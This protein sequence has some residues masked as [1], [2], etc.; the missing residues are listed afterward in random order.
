MVLALV[1]SAPARALDYSPA[2]KVRA[3]V[4]AMSTPLGRELLN[5]AMRACFVWAGPVRPISM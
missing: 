4:T 5:A 3:K 1:P 2:K